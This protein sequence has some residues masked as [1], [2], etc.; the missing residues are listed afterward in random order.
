MTA[1]QISFVRLLLYFTCM[2][3][4]ITSV[5][6]RMAIDSATGKFSAPRLMNATDTV[7]A[8]STMSDPKIV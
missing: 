1:P 6:F 2:K 5:A 7:I 3:N 8:V 4:R